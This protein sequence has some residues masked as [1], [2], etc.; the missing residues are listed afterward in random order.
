MVVIL[1]SHVS[2]ERSDWPVNGPEG[3][4]M[5]STQDRLAPPN[6]G[7]AVVMPRFIVGSGLSCLTA[8]PNPRQMW[9]LRPSAR[10]ATLSSP[11]SS[12]RRRTR[13]TLDF[14]DQG[15]VVE[16]SASL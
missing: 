4:S 10:P 7:F 1:L 9:M 13:A 5:M 12:T 16:L 6:G 14:E 15:A 2:G 3:E 8:P 11:F